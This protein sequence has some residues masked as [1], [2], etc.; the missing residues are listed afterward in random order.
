MTVP[1]WVRVMRLP[2]QKL[3]P[4]QREL[5]VQLERVRVAVES[6]VEP[7]PAVRSWFSRFKPEAPQPAVRGMYI[8]GGVGQ[9]KTMLMDAFYD[10]VSLPKMRMHFHDFMIRVQR[11]MHL[12][13][14]DTGGTVMGTVAR[15]VLGG[16][17]LLCM[18][19]FF[20]NHISDAM[21]LKPLFENIFQMGVV[22]ICTSNRPPE[23]LYQGG[24]NR[25]RFLPFIPLLKSYCDVFNLQAHDFRQEHNFS[26]SSERV[27]RVYYFDP[28]DDGNALTNDFRGGGEAASIVENEVMKVSELRSITVPLSKGGEAFFRFSNLCGSSTTAASNNDKVEVSLGTEGFIALAERFHT[29]WISQV[30]QFDASNHMDGR[31]RSFML[32]IDVLYERNTKLLIASKVPLLQLFG[33]TGI[34]KVAEDFQNRLYTRYV[35]VDKLCSEFPANLSKAEFIKLGGSLGLPSSRTNLFFNAILAPGEDSVSARRVWDICENHRLLLQGNPPAT[36][37]LYRFDIRD[38][39]V[40]ENEFVC[41]RALSRLF[42]MCSGNYLQQHHKRFGDQ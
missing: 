20:V 40:M 18:D 37:H 39:S 30:P 28:K 11:E 10:Q 4:S 21:V 17:R 23:D 36:P 24:L 3:T 31:L 27:Q 9:G 29:I 19:E 6:R 13:K 26:D 41:S 22:V 16:V 1:S 32:L 12:H 25:E 2:F 7:A 35:S 33:M 14:S 38:E 8:Y 5:C 42:H 15:N 34:V